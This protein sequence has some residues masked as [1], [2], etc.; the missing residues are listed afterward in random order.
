MK[1]GAVKSK[2]IT[3]KKLLLAFI[4]GGLIILPF[5]FLGTVLE[6]FTAVAYDRWEA[7]GIPYPIAEDHVS[8]ISYSSASHAMRKRLGWKSGNIVL[9]WSDSQRNAAYERIMAVLPEDETLRVRY[10]VDNYLTPKVME[11]PAP[12]RDFALLLAAYDN[13]FFLLDRHSA[14]KQF[15]HY[16][17][18]NKISQLLRYLMVHTPPH[19]LKKHNK[20]QY[21]P[22]ALRKV[23]NEIE[24]VEPASF[25]QSSRASEKHALLSIAGTILGA[26]DVFDI[27]CEKQELLP[28]AVDYSERVWEVYKT[29][30]FE[31]MD[32]A[33]F[34]DHLEKAI[35]KQNHI[36]GC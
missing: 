27:G 23:L 24:E 2:S 35:I 26:L 4:G 31:D 12:H 33:E 10:W 19:E 28:R 25:Y 3:F 14:S 29:P 20:A 6:T 13:L 32:K 1:D 15:E 11:V 36:E 34:K 21:L 22:L 9:D 8:F 17:K 30:E 5:L 7:E 16:G 18:Y